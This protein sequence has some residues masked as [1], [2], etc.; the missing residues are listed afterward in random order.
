VLSLSDARPP[1]IAGSAFERRPLFGRDDIR[2]KRLHSGG[3]DALGRRM[4]ARP[5]G[6]VAPSMRPGQKTEHHHARQINAVM[7]EA[8]PASAPAFDR[9][10]KRS[11]TMTMTMTIVQRGARPLS[12]HSLFLRMGA[13]SQ[14]HCRARISD[15]IGAR[16]VNSPACAQCGVMYC[17]N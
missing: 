11:M 1:D 16:I 8:A 17:K 5:H 7:G 14:W 15:N 9:K 13:F 10:A 6:R 2:P 4:L 12:A 3:S